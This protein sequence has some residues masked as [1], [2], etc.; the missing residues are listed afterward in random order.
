ML[1]VSTEINLFGM[2]HVKVDYILLQKIYMYNLVEGFSELHDSCNVTYLASRASANTP[3]AS[4]AAAEVPEW[5]RV[6][7]PYKSVVACEHNKYCVSPLKT[8][9]YY[10][11]WIIKQRY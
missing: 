9:E 6:H 4:G 10:A 8:S 5:V 3:A 7:F 2:V 1:W 11:I